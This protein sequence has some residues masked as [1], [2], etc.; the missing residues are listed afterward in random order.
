MMEKG[1]PRCFWL[2]HQEKT[3][4]EFLMCVYSNQ[5][6]TPY[7]FHYDVNNQ[8]KRGKQV[9]QVVQIVYDAR[10]KT[11]KFKDGSSVEMP[12]SAKLYLATRLLR[13]NITLNPESQCKVSGEQRNH[14]L[15]CSDKE[16]GEV[17]LVELH[18][19]NHQTISR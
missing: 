10:P 11:M 16:V 7:L 14:K 4:L 5:L 1:D 2:P 8:L 12:R 13:P 17:H 3:G 9:R 18:E 15:F 6:T 19:N